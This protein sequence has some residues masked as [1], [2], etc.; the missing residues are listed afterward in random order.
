MR[1]QLEEVS[2]RYPRSNR[3]ILKDLSATFEPGKLNAVIGLNGTGKT[4]LFDI[5]AGALPRP[6]GVLGAPS[7]ERIV[8][9]L[10]SVPLF[11][12]LKG[13]DLVRLLMN[14]DHGA[15]PSVGGFPHRLGLNERENA[16]F[17]R[18]WSTRLG[19]MSVGERRWLVTTCI[20]SMDRDLYLFDEPTANV[21]P[22]ARIR[23]LFRLGKLAQREN[24]IVIM[25]T[26]HLHE[27]QYVDSMVYLLHEGR[28][29]FQGPYEAFVNQVDGEPHQNPDQIF[30]RLIEDT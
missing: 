14:I 30:H 17:E 20:S 1:L 5:I 10:Q 16:L 27:L 25:S 9:Q 8:Y 29:R 18:L 4:T 24:T 28:I 6:D 7:P 22:E 3:W 12:T 26:H 23:I 15:T 21:D 13:K 2:F 19:A 11:N